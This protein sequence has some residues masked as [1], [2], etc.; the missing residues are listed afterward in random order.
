MSIVVSLSTLGSSDEYCD[1]FE[2]T[3]L[4]LQPLNWL[5]SDSLL[6]SFIFPRRCSKDL[7]YVDPKIFIGCNVTNVYQ[8]SFFITF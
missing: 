8:I 3:L 4:C 2:V 7:S 5:K 1:F 6:A